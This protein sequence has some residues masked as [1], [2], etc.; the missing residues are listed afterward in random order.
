MEQG[1][2]KDDEAKAGLK[3]TEFR[4]GSDVSIVDADGGNKSRVVSFDE[5]TA[6]VGR[7]TNQE[8]QHVVREPVTEFTAVLIAHRL[9]T[10]LDSDRLIVVGNGRHVGI[11]SPP[12]HYFDLMA[13]GGHL[14]SIAQPL[15]S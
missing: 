6:A 12:A 15:T 8:L 11:A 4:Y 5:A 10:I 7:A 1:N 13:E 9:D 3:V 14:D 2:P